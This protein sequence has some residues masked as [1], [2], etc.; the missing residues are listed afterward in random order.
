MTKQLGIR[1]ASRCP[2]AGFAAARAASAA[3]AVGF[4]I[5]AALAGAPAIAAEPPASLQAAPLSEQD[6]GPFPFLPPLE[7]FVLA[8]KATSNWHRTADFARYVFQAGT[9]E[10]VEV[11]GKLSM[12]HFEAQPP[13]SQSLERIVD[14]YRQLVEE[15]GGT[16]LYEGRFTGGAI[17]AKPRSEQQSREGATFLLRTPERQIW[18][19]VSVPGDGD[20]YVLVVLEQGPLVLRTKPLTP[21]E[22]KKSIAETGRAIIYV[23]FEFDR[24]DLRPDAKPVLDQVFALL[25]GDPALALSIE[26]HT[27][28][29]GNPAYNQTLSERRAAAVR[30]EL[31]R[32]GLG[33]NGAARLTSVGHGASAPIADNGTDEGRARNRRVELVKR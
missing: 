20:E 31:L 5:G 25:K 3:L 32:R 22:L 13:G 33:A 28:N 23:N 2:R 18:A 21:S 15:K 19:Q 6:P 26:G 12:Q 17:D 10:T 1:S 14:S 16:M 8:P 11:G 7:G 30:S 4:A 24:A 29:R 9:D 27:D